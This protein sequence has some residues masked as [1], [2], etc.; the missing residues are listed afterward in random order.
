MNKGRAYL[1]EATSV[2]LPI[3]IRLGQKGLRWTSA[4]FFQK[5]VNYS[6][7]NYII[8]DSKSDRVSSYYLKHVVTINLTQQQEFFF[9]ST[10]FIQCIYIASLAC[11]L[12]CSG[13]GGA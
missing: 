3:N 11:W 6:H 13:G 12:A 8:F 5:F 10:I 2:T 9:Q 1:C 7:K 4:V